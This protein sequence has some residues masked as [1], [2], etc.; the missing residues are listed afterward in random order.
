MSTPL[1]VYPLLVYP[2]LIP[3][4]HPLSLCPLSSPPPLLSPHHLPTFI[5]LVYALPPSTLSQPFP[6][7]P[8]LHPSPTLVPAPPYF[9][10]VPG[11]VASC[12]GQGVFAIEECL[13]TL[14][15]RVRAE[16]VA[17]SNAAA[18]VPVAAR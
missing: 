4:P 15:R 5:P 12:A 17:T 13:E 18:D 14:L 1:R 7:W 16:K 10:H 8:A 6:S 11:Q 9:H 2:L 3:S